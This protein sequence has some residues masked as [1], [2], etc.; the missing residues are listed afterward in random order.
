MRRYSVVRSARL[1]V[2]HHSC[3]LDRWISTRSTHSRTR[4]CLLSCETL[5][6]TIMV[7]SHWT[8][9]LDCWINLRGARS[10]RLVLRSVPPST[11]TGSC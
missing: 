6:L 9:R 10:L 5:S 1:E 3:R 7:A 4:E 2:L 11:P 8:S